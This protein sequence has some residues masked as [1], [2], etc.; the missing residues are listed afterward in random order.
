MAKQNSKSD[1]SS[2][3][4][5]SKKGMVINRKS[6]HTIDQSRAASAPKWKSVGGG[7]LESIKHPGTF[8]VRGGGKKENNVW[9]SVNLKTVGFIMAEEASRQAE[10]HKLALSVSSE[11]MAK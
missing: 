8:I 9:A 5:K 7:L 3:S 4:S 6:N 2:N 11:G 1:T 10:A